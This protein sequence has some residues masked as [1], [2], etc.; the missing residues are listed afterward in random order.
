LAARP[1]AGTCR[2]VLLFGGLRN[3]GFKLAQV[4]TIYFPAAST[5]SIPEVMPLCVRAMIA[6][7]EKICPT[8]AHTDDS[9]KSHAQ[10]FYLQNMVTLPAIMRHA[11][12]VSYWDPAPSALGS[13]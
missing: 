4:D 9:E 7:V 10:H 5:I 12:M 6:A 8:S 3:S 2:T 1:K 11:E 13:E